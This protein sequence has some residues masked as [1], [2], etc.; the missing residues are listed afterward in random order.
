MKASV[1]KTGIVLLMSFGMLL[2]NLEV[3]AQTQDDQNPLKMETNIESLETL[4]LKVKGMSC[5]AGCAN[6]IDRMLSQKEGIVDSKT[7]FDSSSSEVKFD[8]SKISEKEIVA[9]IE[10]RGFKAEVNKED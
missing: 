8:K 7:T 9:L 6:S 3:N 2:L 5:Q 4:Q 10:E 1:K